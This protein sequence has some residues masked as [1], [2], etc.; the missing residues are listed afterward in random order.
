MRC[1]ERKYNGLKTGLKKPL[2][3]KKKQNKIESIY[4]LGFIILF[5]IILR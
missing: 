1:Q 2:T 3:E 5:S 4:F